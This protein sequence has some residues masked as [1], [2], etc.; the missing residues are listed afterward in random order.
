[1]G[2]IILLC[3]FFP[4]MQNDINNNEVNFILLA[5]QKM[6]ANMIENKNSYF[7]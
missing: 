1:M 5:C 4:P 6:D 3:S 7:P 2:Q